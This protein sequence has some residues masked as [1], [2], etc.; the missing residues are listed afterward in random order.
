MKESAKGYI[1]LHQKY[2]CWAISGTILQLSPGQ[3]RAI[4][5]IRDA[6][7]KHTAFFRLLRFVSEVQWPLKPTKKD[8]AWSVWAKT[9]RTLR[10]LCLR[11]GL[12]LSKIRWL[13]EDKRSETLFR[14]TTK[15]RI[16]FSLM[17]Y[18]PKLRVKIL[19][20]I[21]QISLLMLNYERANLD[22]GAKTERDIWDD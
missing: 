12:C 19:I 11:F 4:I 2:H 21:V 5:A 17:C 14:A 20:K 18:N 3:C 8:W 6:L 15:R 9:W 10:F 22:P 13:G 1:E 7:S 16:I